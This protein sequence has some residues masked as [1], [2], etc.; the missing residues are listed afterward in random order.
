MRYVHLLCFLCV[1]IWFLSGC[2]LPE[3]PPDVAFETVARAPLLFD[4]TIVLLG[5]QPGAEAFI[6]T[7]QGGLDT[8]FQ[9]GAE[10]VISI[11]AEQSLS[12]LVQTD[13]LIRFL[14]RQAIPEPFTITARISDLI[15]ASMNIVENLSL[16]HT[17]DVGTIE[18][19]AQDLGITPLTVGTR[20]SSPV[21]GNATTSLG[22]FA[23]S[24]NTAL[25][26]PASEIYPGIQD[27]QPLQAVSEQTHAFS[28][29]A[30]IPI[31]MHRHFEAL[32]IREGTLTL[33]LTNR[34]GWDI[35]FSGIELRNSSDEMVAFSNQHLT[36][37]RGASLS[38]P[39]SLHA[40]ISFERTLSLHFTTSWPA[41]HAS[42]PQVLRFDLQGQLQSSSLA[43]TVRDTPAPFQQSAPEPITISRQFTA[44]SL[45]SSDSDRNRF[46]IDLT[47]R[48]P[49][50]LEDGNGHGPHLHLFSNGRLLNPEQNAFS[51]PIPPGGT[52]R[53]E[54]DLSGK[55]L[56]NRLTYRLEAVIPVS[57]TPYRLQEH[58]GF[59]I[60]ITSTPLE[61]RQ[62]RAS[63]PPLD[64]DPGSE[65]MAL[66]NLLEFADLTPHANGVN[67][68][69]LE[70]TN[71]LTVPLTDGSLTP[72]MPP[73]VVIRARGATEPLAEVVFERSPGP[74]ETVRAVADL[75]GKRIT[76]ALEY[77]FDIGTPHGPDTL[78]NQINNV[79]VHVFTTP[80][81]FTRV[82]A[83]VPPQQGITVTSED[84]PLSDDPQI[85]GALIG[86]AN[87]ELQV[88]NR[89]PIPL[90]MELILRNREA[91]GTY[92]A[93]YEIVRLKNIV[94]GA[95][96]TISVP[97]RLRQVPLAAHTNALLLV[98]TPG[99]NGEMVEINAHDRVDI[100]A[101]GI[102]SIQRV[103]FYSSGESFHTRGSI[104]FDA[105]GL[106]FQRQDFIALS[107]GELG[108]EHITSTLDL[109]MDTLQISF[110]N[111]RRSPFTPS[112]SL[113]IRFI[114][115]V[116]S[117][118]ERYIFAGIPPR[119]TDLSY[120]IPLNGLRIYPEGNTLL[121][122]IRGRLS[123]NQQVG[124]LGF[125]DSLM[126]T[127]A[128]RNVDLQE[129]RVSTSHL[130]ANLT[131]DRN[132]DGW[133]D[134]ATDAE[135]V[136]IKGLTNLR[137]RIQGLQ[138]SGTTFTLHLTTNVVGNVT[139]YL[140]LQGTGP[141]GNAIFLQGKGPFAIPPG[142]TLARIFLEQGAPISPE[143]LIRLRLPGASSP[144]QPITR[145]FT[146][147]SRNSN[148]D[149]FLSAL[150]SYVHILGRA[151]FK[152]AVHLRKPLQLEATVGLTVPLHLTSPTLQMVD[153]LDISTS[154]IAGL[155]TG[156]ED[157]LQI[158]EASLTFTYEN[159]IPLK[160]EAHIDLLDQ[161]GQ[162]LGIQIPESQAIAIAAA[163]ADY[164]G[165]STGFTS[166]EQTI[167]LNRELLARLK[168]ARKAR[169]FVRLETPS[170]T[171]EAYLRASDAIRVRLRARI[172]LIVR[173]N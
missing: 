26:V 57:M 86:S 37:S 147:T 135:T 49:F 164:K 76:P 101:T 83:V 114:R 23:I 90:A 134:I 150:P 167:I 131:A 51:A 80:L 112:D 48:L 73:R 109:S 148:I 122:S 15:E 97:V 2:E 59:A 111:I 69:Y 77:T 162:P 36:L 144:D 6:D 159:G 173:E 161:H 121:Y 53:L 113:V 54:V 119:V 22:P 126:A 33:T 46:F 43:F 158:E 139:L 52:A 82:R 16:S 91:L 70:L 165:F 38:V 30:I 149:A 20:T 100:R 74:G 99:S 72:G 68:L 106:T 89:L 146:L 84:V 125:T 47:N 34:L 94:V 67:R 129:A 171:A 169:L 107:E 7:T 45:T 168:Q 87:L 32:K 61:V 58:N 96:Q 155:P 124:S 12:N 152:D 60:T 120:R 143:H 42:D 21:N 62:V 136:S 66:S 142:D 127:I 110:P 8:L 172:K 29:E 160:G 128:I 93:G 140:A 153:T 170:Q 156:P 5:P 163:P 25:T 13:T 39:L 145:T 64:L 154:D 24:I 118:P 56:R 55:S 10:N 117:Q 166:G 98:S 4:K 104:A 28:F 105:G 17:I 1:I 132:N 44:V 9:A 71:N 88:N 137:Q 78:F 3:G 130:V 11:V 138:V 151:L 141:E 41:Q 18:A 40:G 65:F 133:L 27:N 157:A 50:P 108:I 75:S 19:E 79:S 31:G 102:A 103:Y 14:L 116:Q 85:A 35:S 63:V 123:A 92:P 95:N 81:Q 115:G